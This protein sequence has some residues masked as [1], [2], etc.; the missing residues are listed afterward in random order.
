MET[1]S[2]GSVTRPS[3]IRYAE[4]ND[5]GSLGAAEEVASFPSGSVA[6]FFAR[7]LRFDD[8]DLKYILG[9]VPIPK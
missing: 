3:A 7:D 1:G 8:E 2:S 5:D 4:V 9:S 6:S